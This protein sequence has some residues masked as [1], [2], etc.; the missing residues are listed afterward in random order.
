MN[1]KTAF[2]LGFLVAC[3]EARLDPRDLVGAADKIAGLG[4]VGSLASLA[5][6]GSVAAPLGLGHTAGILAEN[7][8]S[9]DLEGTPEMRKRY[10]I[11]QLQNL[12]AAE[13]AK[14]QNRLIS[15]ALQ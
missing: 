15:K 12:V 7:G 3:A 13:Q 11:R 10:L 1:S 4:T 8:L 9:A 2:K 14:S 5:A 6:M